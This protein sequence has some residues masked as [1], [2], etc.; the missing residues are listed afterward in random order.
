[1]TR[2]RSL[3]GPLLLTSL[4]A[5]APALAQPKAAPK[6]RPT[7][8]TETEP[9]DRGL[10]EVRGL[11][12][13]G[14][15]DEALTKLREMNEATP[16]DPKVTLL[17]GR[18]L[19]EM[20]KP[21]E[22]VALYRKAIDRQ[23]TDRQA[24]DRQATDAQAKTPDPSAADPT[25]AKANGVTG[26][27]ASELAPIFIDLQRL[28]REMGEWDL[29]LAVC[30]EYQTRFGDKSRG[31][32][33]GWVSEEVESLIRSDRLGPKAVE[34]IGRAVEES[35][36]DEGLARLWIQALYHTD[37]SV[38]ALEAAGGLD[39]RLEAHGAVLMEQAAMAIEENSF[40]HAIAAIDLALAADPKAS[41]K[42]DALHQKARSLRKL[43]RLDESLLAY[44][45]LLAESRTSRL[46][47]AAGLEKAQILAQELNRKEDALVAY[48]ELLA[49]LGSK[50][51]GDDREVAGEVQLAMAECALAL[52][53]PEE[54]GAIYAAL[55]DSAAGSPG[56]ARALF[57][58]AEMLFFQG[59]MKEA[60]TT[61]YQLTDDYPQDAFVN[62][63]LER[64]L[65][66]GENADQGGA[67]LAALSQAVYQRRLGRADRALQL[68]SD[69]I[70]AH[71]GSRA[72]DD[73]RFLRVRLLLD[74]QQ[75]EPAQ[76]A[77]DAL[78]T[79]F[80]DSPLASRGLV[81][82]A[83]RLAQRPEGRR[84]AEK[85]YERVL[86]QFPECIE[87]SAVRAAL[88]DLK[89]KLR[90]SSEALAPRSPS[91]KSST[92]AGTV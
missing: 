7:P 47:R 88:R 32:A 90:E 4:V 48:R 80:R 26:G 14:K 44:D 11:L 86:L 59:K 82:V 83:Q 25:W 84:M 91:W 43:R 53:R 22:A 3:A 35:P 66:I 60:E 16:G 73:L 13:L 57:E 89:S 34:T 24:T 29:A 18:Q 70:N 79:G 72:Q 36:K 27:A 19:A 12:R 2:L 20:D 76:L 68:V 56:R 8:A 9:K 67:P 37:R 78:A 38:E 61:Y 74:L 39:A 49:A 92:P 1:M 46:G 28:H 62:D 87:G 71:P 40:E 69:A 55:A 23:A 21:D 6:Q 17:L 45:A 10:A 63:A 81:E 64:I 15:S 75:E 42:A 85:L 51:K 41:L 31:R 58:S 52:G 5:L 50:P 65:V 77:A 33:T 54:A 30:L